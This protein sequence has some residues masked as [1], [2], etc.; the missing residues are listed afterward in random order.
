MPA[1]P[2]FFSFGELMNDCPFSD[3]YENIFIWEEMWWNWK[4]RSYG[5]KYYA[6][7]EE[8]IY[9]SWD[10]TQ[11]PGFESDNKKGD[12]KK[13][14]EHEEHI[15]REVKQLR[16]DIFE[17]ETFVNTIKDGWGLDIPNRRVSVKAYTG[18]LDVNYFWGRQEPA[19]YY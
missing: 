4:C 1:A 10:R 5:Y 18:A 12:P 7:N 11:R 13:V 6:P 17:D 15:N 3:E 16:K 14:K 19:R 2:F 9:H 8:I